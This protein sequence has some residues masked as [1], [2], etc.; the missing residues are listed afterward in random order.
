[1]K[2]FIVCLCVFAFFVGL[3]HLADA[4]VQHLKDKCAALQVENRRLS[5]EV[6][7]ANEEL[8]RVQDQSEILGLAR[9]EK[10]RPEYI[11]YLLKSRGLEGKPVKLETP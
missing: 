6:V 9:W 5:Q 2:N 11:A 4:K 8:S 7:A 1:M 3:V 10:E